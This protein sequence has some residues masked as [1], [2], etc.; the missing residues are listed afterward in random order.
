MK[1]KLRGHFIPNSHLDREWTLD[2]QKHRFLLVQFID[3]LLEIFD[4]IPEYTFLLDSQTVPLEDYLAVRPGKKN[5]IS[6][7]VQSGRLVI[8]PW[9]TAPDCNTIS[10]ESVVRNLL[11][12]HKTGEEFGR[13]MKIG[14]TPFGFGQISQLPQIYSGFDIDFIF[15]Y[16]GITEYETPASE[17]KWKA[18]DGT[19]TQCSRFGALKRYNF[20]MEVWRPVV[21]GGGMLDREFRWQK[22]SVPFKRTDKEHE[23]DHYFTMRPHLDVDQDVILKAWNSLLKKEKKHFKTHVI[24]LMQG[25]DTTMPHELES[26]LLEDIRKHLKSGEEVFFSTLPD[27]VNDL[28]KALKGKR[29]KI[30][31]GEM[32]RPGPPTPYVTN[33]ENIASARI[34]QKIHQEKASTLLQRLA[35]P[36]CSMMNLLGDEYPKSFLDLA[37]KYLLQS[38]PHD[39]VA[40]CGLDQLEKDADYRLDQVENISDCLIDESLG[41]LQAR[42][43]TTD[44]DPD[45]IVITV[46]NP[47][48]HPRTET[49]EAFIDTP[50]NTGIADF[51]IIDHRGEPVQWD[52]VSRKPVEKTVRNNTDLTMA[53]EGWEVKIFLLAEDLPAMGYRIYYLQGVDVMKLSKERI[54]KNSRILENEHLRVEFNSD[55][56]IDLIQKKTG[57]RYCGIHYFEDDGEKGQGWESR[58]PSEDTLVSS[59]GCPVT[60]SIIENSSLCGAI[61][62]RYEMSIPTDIIHDNTWHYSRRGDQEVPLVIET[63]FILKA[64]ARRLDC[65]TRFDNCAKHHRLRLILPTHIPAKVSAAETPFDVVEREIDRGPDHPYSQAPNPQYPCLRFVD[66]SDGKQGLAVLTKGIHEYEV[67]DD[68]ERAIALTMMRAFEVTLC[69]VSFRWERRPDQPLSQEPGP[70]ELRYSLYP[71]RGNWDR[72]E[73]MTETEHFTLPL[74]VAQSTP[75]KKGEKEDGLFLPQKGFFEIKPPELV[76]SAWKKAEKGDSHILRLY[77]PTSRE[78]K[79]NVKFYRKPKK[80]SLANLN[81]EPLKTRSLKISNH[82]ITLTAAP[83]KILTLKIDF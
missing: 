36:L 2:F 24:P 6:E 42:I 40:G 38:H 62:V 56:T 59:L 39:T 69:T 1:R 4:K 60:I 33:L 5:I 28:K 54:A 37:W 74:Q 10:G 18:P 16:R 45:S 20:F 9:Y 81:E 44:A 30:F 49:V 58:R 83:K 34:R 35:E 7:H 57:A 11:W 31:H 73:V 3:R 15:F 48:S 17:F 78:L 82:G 25:M 61:R 63:D 32:R 13:V 41:R 66:V 51:T 47:S 19:M 77:N 14:Y 72:G 76:L 46:F 26:E 8:G 65:I 79:G 70:H 12:G 80:A 21:F 43:D 23:Y 52:Y 53:L 71:H 67:T 27:Y 68:E 55:G 75:L 64:G 22:G 29:L 50:Y